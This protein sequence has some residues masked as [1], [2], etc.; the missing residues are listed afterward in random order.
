VGPRMADA[1]GSDA[2][3]DVIEDALPS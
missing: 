2:F 1:V 3:M